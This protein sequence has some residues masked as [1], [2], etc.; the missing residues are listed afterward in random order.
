M[1]PVLKMRKKQKEKEREKRRE[2][3]RTRKRDDEEDDFGKNYNPNAIGEL[4]SGGAVD[5]ADKEHYQERP[6]T[7][8]DLEHNLYTGTINRGV[9]DSYGYYSGAQA[10][11]MGQYGY[12]PNNRNNQQYGYNNQNQHGYQNYGRQPQPR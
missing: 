3:K 12:N 1:N 9:N 6:L 7:W 4:K 11:T 10:N 5:K 2:A 8:Q